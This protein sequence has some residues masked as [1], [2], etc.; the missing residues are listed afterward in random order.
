[1][2]TSAEVSL[3]LLLLDGLNYASWFTCMLDIFRAMGPQIE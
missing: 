3:E 2:S 1:M